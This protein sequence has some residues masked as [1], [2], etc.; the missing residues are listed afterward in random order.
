MVNDSDDD[1][2]GEEWGENLGLSERVNMDE[3]GDTSMGMDDADQFT[4]GQ[5]LETA[6]HVVVPPCS[7]S[8]RT[9]EQGQEISA[10]SSPVIK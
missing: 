7:K 10:Q 3:E 8:K 4:N 5:D 2:E 6:R 9:L 1:I